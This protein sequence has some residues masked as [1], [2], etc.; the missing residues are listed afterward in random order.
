MLPQMSKHQRFFVPLQAKCRLHAIFW[1]TD[2]PGCGILLDRH[3]PAVGI[4]QQAHGQPG[5]ERAA[6]APGPCLRRGAVSGCH[7]VA[8]SP[9]RVDAGLRMDAAVGSG[10]LCHWRLLPVPVLYHHRFALRP[11]VHDAGPSGSCRNGMGGFGRS[12]GT[13]QH[14]GHAGHADGYCH[15]RV[16]ARRPPPRVAETAT[17]RRALCRRCRR[18]PG[19]RTGAEQG[20]HDTLRGHDGQQPACVAR[21]LLGQFPALHRRYC[22]FHL[23][24]IL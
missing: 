17:E 24:I 14:R 19:C 12:D 2:F 3:G 4:W 7:R 6:H 9:R 16:R 11:A 18:L 10:G 15:F 23:I 22:R 21:T 13:G 5:A 8:A 1:R 20:G